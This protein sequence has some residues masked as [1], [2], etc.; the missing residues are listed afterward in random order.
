MKD[1]RT[2]EGVERNKPGEFVTVGITDRSSD[3][4]DAAFELLSDARRRHALYRLRTRDQPIGIA[5]LAEDVAAELC[6][7][8]RG[9]VSDD[10][11]EAMRTALYHVHLPK[12]EA[13]GCVRVHA[14][15]RHVA[16]DDGITALAPYLSLAA[17]EE[18]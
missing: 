9:D 8:Q 14:G 4:L 6:D 17:A 7:E 11:V 10:A 12:L 16:V 2:L 5:D 1:D 15:S 3:R 18:L 13:E